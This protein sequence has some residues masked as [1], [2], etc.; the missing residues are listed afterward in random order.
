MF[1]GCTKSIYSG[2]VDKSGSVSTVAAAVLFTI[3][4]GAGVAVDMTRLTARHVEMQDA[5]DAAIITTA[6]AYAGSGNQDQAIQK[7]K[8]IFQ[9]NLV[10]AAN[11]AGPVIA[12][13]NDTFVGSYSERVEMTLAKL[14]MD[15]ALVSVSASAIGSSG[16][17]VCLLA[18]NPNGRAV[19]ITGTADLIAPECAVMSN[20]AD[21][22]GL[23]Q[24]GSATG[25]ANT[26]CVVGGFSGSNLTNAPKENCP[27]I[28]DPYAD[29]ARQ[30]AQAASTAGC[31]N[32]SDSIGNTAFG[33]SVSLPFVFCAPTIRVAQHSLVDFY[34][35]NSE[36]DGLVIIRGELIV[37]AGATLMLS[38][39]TLY[40]DGPDARLT[41]QAG[42]ELWT[43]PPLSGPLKEFR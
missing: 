21:T 12:Y 4:L 19:S 38:N 9:A 1:R 2:I 3:V 34:A 35:M 14:V 30:V 23:Y 43:T 5:L 18:V 6:K 16:A 31:L 28:A 7:G 15:D 26:F 42:A 8:E 17:P 13:Q 39:T 33:S 36:A 32:W 10:D 37:P 29:A 25:I 11:P 41:V 40:F 27:P 24:Q 20:S 22:D